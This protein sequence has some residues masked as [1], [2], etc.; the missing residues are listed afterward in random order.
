[1]LSGIKSGKNK[2]YNG[3]HSTKT[4]TKKLNRCFTAI[5]FQKVIPLGLEPR[6]IH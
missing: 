6:P 1:M 4:S 5:Y 3:N 2:M